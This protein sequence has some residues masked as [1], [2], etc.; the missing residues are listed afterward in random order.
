[1]TVE[2][3]AIILDKVGERIRFEREKNGLSRE[4]FAEII[5]LST[6]YIGQIERDQRGMSI[7]TLLSISNS[8]NVSTDYIIKGYEHYIEYVSSVVTIEDFYSKDLENEIKEILS[9]LAG[10]P[11]EKVQLVKSIAKLVLPYLTK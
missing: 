7:N 8:L 10:A 11:I 9:I 2:T 5:G 3:E 1:M 6:F 4:D